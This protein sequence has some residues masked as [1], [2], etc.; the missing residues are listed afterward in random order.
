MQ[1][2]HCIVILFTGITVDQQLFP[3]IN[4][5]IRNIRIRLFISSQIKIIMLL[6]IKNNNEVLNYILYRYY[7]MS[8]NREEKIRLVT[9]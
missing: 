7:A 5:S 2:T 6:V 9:F 4:E 8:S 3:V 1:L